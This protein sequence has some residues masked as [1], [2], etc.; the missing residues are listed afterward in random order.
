MYTNLYLLFAA[1]LLNLAKHH[2]LVT[3]ITNAE[4]KYLS[5][6]NG[7]QHNHQSLTQLTRGLHKQQFGAMWG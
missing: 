3:E 4:Q 1:T 6:S 7:P 5:S 2:L